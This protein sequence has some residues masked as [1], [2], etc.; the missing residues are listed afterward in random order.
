MGA[1]VCGQSGSGVFAAGVTTSFFLGERLAGG[2]MSHLQAVSDPV[3][4]RQRAAA[5]SLTKSQPWSAKPVCMDISE[6]V[7]L[8]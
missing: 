7:R 1:S 5:L 6:S 3:V 8:S 2:R 4:G